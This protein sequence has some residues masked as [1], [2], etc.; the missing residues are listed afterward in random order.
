MGCNKAVVEDLLTDLLGVVT[1]QSSPSESQ[2]KPKSKRVKMAKA[3]APVT[4][5]DIEDTLPISKLAKV[6]QRTHSF[7][8]KAEAFKK[9]LVCKTKEAVGFLA[10][11]NNAEVK[12]MILLDQAKATKQAQDQ[13]EEKTQAAEA[14]AYVLRTKAKESEA[15]I[16]KAEAELREALATKASE[17][18]A[19]NKK[20]YAEGQANVRDAYN[21]QAK[22]GL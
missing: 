7:A 3:K 13:V 22:P 6:I 9:E 8:T 15:K 18:K 19:A 11:L 5:M 14:V 10:S 17:I 1:V 4:Q 20:A 2:S 12:M 16:A 21:E